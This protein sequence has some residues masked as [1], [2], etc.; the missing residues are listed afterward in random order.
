MFLMKT[1]KNESEYRF[2]NNKMKYQKE[3]Q[4]VRSCC[5]DKNGGQV[6]DCIHSSNAPFRK[7]CLAR[8]VSQCNARTQQLRL[9]TDILQLTFITKD[10][11]NEQHHRT[12]HRQQRHLHNNNIQDAV[13][14]K[15]PEQFREGTTANNSNSPCLF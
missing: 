2:D 11:S 10:F 5:S 9:S 4:Y 6:Q 1:Q 15:R 13:V 3:C 8:R 7:N 14:Q 12:I